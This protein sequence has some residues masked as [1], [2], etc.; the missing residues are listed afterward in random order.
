MI[1]YQ[2]NPQN[3]SS[4]PWYAVEWASDLSLEHDLSTQIGS[5]TNGGRGRSCSQVEQ[6]AFAIVKWAQRK[7]DPFQLFFPVSSRTLEGVGLF[8]PYLWIRMFDPN[9]ISQAISRD[10]ARIDILR[11]HEG[12]PVPIEDAFIQEVIQKCKDITEGNS[13][14]IAEGSFVRV[15]LGRY[16][17]LCGKVESVSNG[18]AGIRIAL[19]AKPVNLFAPLTALQNLGTA[20]RDYFYLGN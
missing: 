7:R 12:Q 14:G 6:V 15:L 5:G 9:G 10:R 19:K 13:Q 18:I 2:G 4:L 11:D 1:V 3:L 17:M 8:S 20:Q 16:R